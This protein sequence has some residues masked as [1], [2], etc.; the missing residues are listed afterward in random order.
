MLIDSSLLISSDLLAINADEFNK[1]LLWVREKR[2]TDQ[3]LRQD[4]GENKKKFIL[5]CFGLMILNGQLKEE[6]VDNL[7]GRLRTLIT[8]AANKPL[9]KLV[10]N[11]DGADDESTKK[12]M[13]IMN[14]LGQGSGGG[15]CM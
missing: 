2:L 1:F 14:K 4:L 15:V 10:P 3:V 8:E 12:L 9:D 13:D 5:E 7:S 11:I 6:D